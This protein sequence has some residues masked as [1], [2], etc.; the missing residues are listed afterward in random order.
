MNN[1]D[2]TGLASWLS[3]LW[4]GVKSA[5]SRAVSAVK[6]VFTPARTVSRP[7]AAVVVVAKSAAAVARK[8]VTPSARA[9]SGGGSG[10]GVRNSG[11]SS[12][13]G[14]SGGGVS[15]S[16]LSQTSYNNS[17]LKAD[18][19]A[20]LKE[21]GASAIRILTA[22]WN[23][24]E[25]EAGVG[26]GFGASASIGKGEVEILA[27]ADALHLETTHNGTFAGMQRE[28]GLGLVTELIL[29]DPSTLCC[30]RTRVMLRC[31]MTTGT[32]QA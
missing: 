31:R 12:G 5:V 21:L 6:R 24:L 18:T 17:S 23:S 7:A 14:Y 27:K 25:V 8:T 16:T 30:T 2:P 22:A 20:L 29:L 11:G 3:K 28:S 13:S 15:V 32:A 9:S 4:S 10:G 19:S 1:E 26:M